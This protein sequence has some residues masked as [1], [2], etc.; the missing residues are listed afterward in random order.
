[1]CEEYEEEMILTFRSR[2]EM[3]WLVQCQKSNRLAP[4]LT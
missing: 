1:M 2:G 3:P 4:P